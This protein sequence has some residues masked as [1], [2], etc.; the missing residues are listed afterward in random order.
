ML[1]HSIAG[2]FDNP[3]QVAI[4]IH[5]YL[6]RQS[7]A[8]GEPKYD[9]L[10]RRLAMG[11][12]VGAPPSRWWVTSTA[13]RTRNRHGIA[14]NSRANRTIESLTLALGTICIKGINL[15]GSAGG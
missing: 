7:L 4:A 10:E 5:N 6:R 14:Q 13:R 9:D 8:N 2:V 3:D 12:M 11:P 15:V 1:R